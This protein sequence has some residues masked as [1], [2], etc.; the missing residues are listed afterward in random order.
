MT[1]NRRRGPDPAIRG[2]QIL[3]YSEAEQMLR[4]GKSQTEVAA[5]FG[6]H[7][8]AISVAIA[9]GNIKFDTGFKRRLPWRVKKE[10]SNLAIPR[11]L[12]LAVRVQ[13]GDEMSP[14]ME[15]LARG[16]LHR[17]EE[18]DAVIHYDPD[19]APF[20]FRVPRRAGIDKGLFREPDQP[21]TH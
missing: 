17:L 21:T 5:R 6:V 8:S 1:S 7:P 18:L 4:A 3:D 9:R 2:K 16:F 19:V 14:E 10:H 12:R 13:E 11:A 20:F 15:K